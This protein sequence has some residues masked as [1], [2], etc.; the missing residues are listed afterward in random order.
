MVNSDDAALLAANWLGT[1]K[2]WGQGD[3]NNDGL[4]NDVD[5]TILA[6]NW[7]STSSASVPEPTVCALLA[8]LLVALACFRHHQSFRQP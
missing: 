5:A 7:Q 4:V 1:G 3:F 8:A 6:T 2:T